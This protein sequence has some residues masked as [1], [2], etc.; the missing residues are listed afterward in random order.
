[1]Q[2]TQWPRPTSQIIPWGVHWLSAVQRRRH[3]FPPHL[4]VA[5]Q[6]PSPAQATQRRAA[7]SH[8]SPAGQSRLFT[9]G[10]ASVQAP[11]AQKRPPQSVPPAA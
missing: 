4:S 7:T 8:T 10:V 5:G 2:E 6:S 1:M 11:A 3:T 9:H